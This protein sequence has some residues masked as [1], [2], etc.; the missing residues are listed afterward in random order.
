MD[1]YMYGNDVISMYQV[2]LYTVKPVYKDHPGY[3]RILAFMDGWMLYTGR[4]IFKYTPMQWA[5]TC[6]QTVSV[7]CDGSGTEMVNL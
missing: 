1:A 3:M 4:N 2:E 7:S 5:F 6:T